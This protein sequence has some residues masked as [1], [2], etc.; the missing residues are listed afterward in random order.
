MENVKY[1]FIVFF[2]FIISFIEG[3][4]VLALFSVKNKSLTKA[5][6]YGFVFLLAI[7]ELISVPFVYSNSSFLNL[8]ITYSIFLIVSLL[9]FIFRQFKYGFFIKDYHFNFFKYKNRVTMLV[10]ILL[11]IFTAITSSYLEHTDA[12][13]GYFITISTIAYQTNKITYD[14]PTVYDGA[15][16]KKVDTFR[17]QIATWELFV[18]YISKIGAVHPAIVA[19]SILPF[20]LIIF[21]FMAV[22]NFGIQLVGNT[23]AP[24]FILLYA[25]LVLFDGSNTASQGA[26]MLLRIWQGKAMLANFIIPMLMSSILSMYSEKVKWKQAIWNLILV[27]A[28][29]NLS[30]VGIY[31]MSIVYF[32]TGM[33][34]LVL[35]AKRKNWKNVLG[36]TIKVFSTMLPVIIVA[37]FLYMKLT[38]SSSGQT[39]VSTPPKSWM[40]VLYS[41]YGAVPFFIV[42]ILCFVHIYLHEKDIVK[43][44]FL[45]GVPITLF[46]SFLNPVLNKI[47]AQHITGV[48]VYWRLY[49]ILPIYLIIA[50]AV[51]NLLDEYYSGKETLSLIISA[52]I[53]MSAG[54]YFYTPSTGHFKAHSN[55]Y[56]I[57]VNALAAADKIS[58]DT[59]GESTIAI[60][61]E[62]LSYLIRQYDSKIDVVRSRFFSEDSRII[63]NNRTYRWLYNQIYVKNNINSDEVISLLKTLNVRYIYISQNELH[64]SS[65]ALKKG[66]IKTKLYKIIH[67]RKSGYLYKVL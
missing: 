21:C 50:Y 35:Q 40:S 10:A 3:D 13:D 62:R 36:I 1:I 24:L 25:L 38:S 2:M 5:I 19:H 59:N 57:N 28:G 33:P 20:V 43:K 48:D 55:A 56:K 8:V 16:S 39:Y 34:Y 9:I 45:I 51:S 7:F 29:I 54:T 47:V 37:L 17:P 66:P 61:P 32:V 31:L 64:N 23:L 53:I 14:E 52:S 46:V 11:I 30:V 60:F 6:T 15:M 65:Y 67:T 27:I 18:A 12:D 63:R 49:W 41:G 26:F 44:C 4:N 22:W 42:F 58:K